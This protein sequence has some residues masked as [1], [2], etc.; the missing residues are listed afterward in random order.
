MEGSS[1]PQ[2]PIDRLRFSG[3]EDIECF[4]KQSF[5]DVRGIP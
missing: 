2:N 5:G 3:P 4:S 1:R